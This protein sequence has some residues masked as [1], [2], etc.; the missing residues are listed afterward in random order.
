VNWRVVNK[1]K[2]LSCPEEGTGA[3]MVIDFNTTQPQGCG[4]RL[5]SGGEKYI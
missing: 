1:G 2:E 4:P 3:N 5:W